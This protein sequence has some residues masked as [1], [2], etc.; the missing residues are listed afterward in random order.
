[1]I[2]LESPFFVRSGTAGS[3]FS[4]LL[5]RY[6]C[7]P[8]GSFSPPVNAFDF[9]VPFASDDFNDM[10][11]KTEEKDTGPVT[12]LCALYTFFID[13]DGGGGGSSS[14][15]SSGGGGGGSSISSC[16]GGGGGLS[17][18]VGAAGKSLSAT[19]SSNPSSRIGGGGT[20]EQSDFTDCIVE[21]I[22]GSPAF[23]E[24]RGAT[25]AVIIDSLVIC[26]RREGLSEIGLSFVGDAF[27]SL[28]VF[29]D[30]EGEVSCVEV[31]AALGI[32]GRVRATFSAPSDSQKLDSN[33]ILSDL[34]FRPSPSPSSSN[35]SKAFLSF[36]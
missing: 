13:V 16:I 20:I 6:P 32:D 21:V 11:E 4:S 34:S 14:S 1:M 22:L 25:G 15:S 10:F 5:G 3:F 36:L 27:V 17:S 30:F 19:S 33:T 2:S 35:A 23:D 26:D 24:S 28:F 9:V 31:D 12:S 29:I 18:V 8:I 7:Q